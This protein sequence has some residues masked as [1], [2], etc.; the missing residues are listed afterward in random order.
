MIEILLQQ[1]LEIIQEVF[2]NDDY[3]DHIIYDDYD[4]HIIYDHHD[5]YIFEDYE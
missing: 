2:T 5:E 3:D 1:L 4:D